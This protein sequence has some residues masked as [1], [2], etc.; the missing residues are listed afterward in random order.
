MCV[1][2]YNTALNASEI[3]V[4]SSL[5]LRPDLFKECHVLPP[6]GFATPAYTAMQ[7]FIGNG[8]RLS[9]GVYQLLKTYLIVVLGAATNASRNNEVGAGGL[10]GGVRV[11]RGEVGGHAAAQPPPG[12]R[13]AHAKLVEEVGEGRADAGEGAEVVGVVHA[14]LGVVR[15]EGA[16]GGGQEG[17][18]ARGER[19]VDRGDHGGH[20]FWARRGVFMRGPRPPGRHQPRGR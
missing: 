11:V 9:Q 7:P 18:Q 20:A 4:D 8:F 19:D 15:V 6:E 17:A 3:F 12:G 5:A 2:R 14:H 13:D 1:R 16:E 10:P